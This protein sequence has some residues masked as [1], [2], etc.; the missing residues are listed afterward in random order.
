MQQQIR[1]HYKARGSP[2]WADSHVVL[3]SPVWVSFGCQIETT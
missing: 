3:N 1:L 2:A